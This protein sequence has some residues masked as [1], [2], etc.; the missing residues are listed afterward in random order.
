MNNWQI[1]NIW[2]NICQKYPWVIRFN[3]YLYEFYTIFTSSDDCENSNLIIYNNCYFCYILPN[4]IKYGGKGRCTFTPPSCL[5]VS[6]RL[7][8]LAQVLSR[9]TRNVTTRILIE[10]NHAHACVKV[11]SI[12]SFC[13]CCTK[14]WNILWKL[15]NPL[16]KKCYLLN[17]NLNSKIDSLFKQFFYIKYIWIFQKLKW[18][19]GNLNFV[20][21]FLYNLRT[22]NYF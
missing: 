7:Y 22:M 15:F 18:K 3:Q 11:T 19:E 17:A 14:C 6:A 10:M 21:I 8:I 5:L 20:H 12:V 1:K 4:S 9:H 2:F 16:V 13:Y